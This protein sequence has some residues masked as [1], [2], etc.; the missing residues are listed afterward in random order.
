M[1]DHEQV[2]SFFKDIDTQRY[3]D[4]GV[5]G[6]DDPF[7]AAIKAE[8]EKAQY[9]IQ[10]AEKEVSERYLAMYGKDI[11]LCKHLTAFAF[12]QG[13]DQA[14]VEVWSIATCEPFWNK[15]ECTDWQRF[16]WKCYFSQDRYTPGDWS[17][18]NRS[19]D[20]LRFS[21]G[22]SRYQIARTLGNLTPEESTAD[23]S[24][25]ENGK[26]VFGVK[27]LH[28]TGELG[29]DYSILD[30]YAMVRKGRW[31][32]SLIDCYR[33]IQ[34]EELKVDVQHR[35]LGADVIKHKFK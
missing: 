12:E 3:C 28:R 25:T 16:D 8:N 5:A 19:K 14:L 32:L 13:L 21:D 33:V 15:S 2:S 29:D 6:N 35:F 11:A 20:F 7:L 26:L 18:G 30:I 23:F 22:E 24:L 34:I 4:S 31:A 1:I 9:A 27:A 10:S 17:C